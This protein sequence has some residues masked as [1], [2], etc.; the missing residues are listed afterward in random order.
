MKV[1]HLCLSCFYI[2]DFS[3]QENELVAQNIRDGHDVLVIASTE[4]YGSDRQLTYLMPSTYIGSEGAKVVRIPYKSFLP[5]K[6]MRKLRIHN[7]VYSLIKEFQPDL[8]IFH[9]LCGGELLTV[10]KYKKNN[11]EVKFYIDNHTDFNNSANNFF[12]KYIL[13][14]LYYKT[15][16]KISTKYASKVLCVSYDTLN[17]A[18]SF[19]KIPR[20]KLEFYPIGGK[21]LP[22][23]IYE[24]VRK[25]TR[26]LLSIKNEDRLFVQSGKIDDKKKLI[27][28]LK[29]FLK[30]DNPNC[31]FIIVGS[32]QNDIKIIA[33]KLISFDS[34]V[35]FL[36]WK[37]PEELRKILCAAD[38]YVQPGSQSAT[39]QMSICCQCAV[40]LA[41]VV[42]HKAY[43]NG[44][45]WLVGD[46]TTLEKAFEEACSISS[47]GLIDMMNH[48]KEIA[49]EM[50][51]Y[52]KL[53]A[54][55]YY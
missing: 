11:P 55:L 43:I 34:R 32:L 1:V 52:Q 44:N 42:S 18:N 5:Q 7:G 36:G 12:S 45:G 15:I 4:S 50:L 9:G 22:Q 46:S 28:A 31:K 21:I 8:I 6:V 39:M 35:Q 40:I 54:R 24:E 30:I 13:H 19:Y 33:E 16:A 23:N 14:Y 53:A 3:Y 17:F 51:D 20:E 2:D 41:D 29:A 48:S 10:A 37:S 47:E 26:S 49:S 27:E 25:K 38:V